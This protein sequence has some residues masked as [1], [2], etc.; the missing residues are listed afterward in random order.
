[1]KSSE[2][3]RG[4][5]FASRRCP[6]TQQGVVG[7]RVDMAEVDMGEIGSPLPIAFALSQTNLLLARRSGQF[8]RRDGYDPRKY[9]R[10]SAGGRD[11]H[12]GHGQEKSR[13]RFHAVRPHAAPASVDR[14]LAPFNGRLVPLVSFFS[15]TL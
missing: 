9:E 15:A 11:P 12:M 7:N 13:S 2:V 5:L 10:A 1:M 3:D 8:R 4:R 14:K 6:T